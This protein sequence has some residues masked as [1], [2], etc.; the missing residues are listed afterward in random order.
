MFERAATIT[1]NDLEIRAQIAENYTAEGDL[2]TA[3]KIVE[4]LNFAPTERGFGT[5]FN[6]SVFQRRFDDAE[7]M[8]SKAMAGEGLPPI[9]VAI[10]HSA[11]ANIRIAKG[12]RAG[13]QPLLLQ[14]EGELNQLRAASENSVLLR[15]ALLGVEANLNR[16]EESHDC[17]FPFKT[18]RNDSWQFPREEEGVARAYVALRDFDRALPLIEHALRVPAVESLTTAYLRVDPS[19]DPIRNDPRFQKIAAAK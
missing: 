19:W 17:E 7:Q 10:S 8:I 6:G 5:K 16:R 14:A 4:P 12:D 9:F 3:W 1:P 13:A 11:L 2:A 15:N 18:S